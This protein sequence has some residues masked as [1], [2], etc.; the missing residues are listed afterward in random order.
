LKVA[1]R[2]AL[3]L[4]ILLLLLLLLYCRPERLQFR[5]VGR[6]ERTDA[7]RGEEAKWI[8]RELKL[9]QS[10]DEE[11]AITAIEKVSHSVPACTCTAVCYC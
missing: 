4:N 11:A 3:L 5:M 6:G 9:T 1:D 7:E 10:V 8:L 2:L